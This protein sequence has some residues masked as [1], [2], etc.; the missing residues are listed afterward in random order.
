MCSLYL[1]LVRVIAYNAEI[2][3]ERWLVSFN[4][5]TLQ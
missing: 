4:I 2:R 1:K 3:G 5:H